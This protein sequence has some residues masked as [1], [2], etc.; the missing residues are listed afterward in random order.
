MVSV[1][2]RR[3]VVPIFEVA[4]R[5]FFFSTSEPILYINWWHIR[6]NLKIPALNGVRFGLF[7]LVFMK[8]AHMLHATG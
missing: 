4:D 1:G 6:K 2:C 7:C 3:V 8:L 5:V